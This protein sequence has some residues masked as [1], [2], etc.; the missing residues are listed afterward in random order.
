MKNPSAVRFAWVLAAFSL[1]LLSGGAACLAEEAKPP[2]VPELDAK[3]VRMKVPGKLVTDQVFR[4]SITMKNTG[5][6][7]W[8]EG[9]FGVKLLAAGPV[10]NT[11]WGTSYIILGQGRKIQPGTEFTFGSWLRAPGEPGEHVFQWQVAKARGTT[12][13]GETTE[14]RTITVEQRP[15]EPPP[16]PPVQ[17]KTGKHIL[18]FDDFAYA[19]SFKLPRKAAGGDPLFASSGLA[20]RTM[21]DG[22]KR[23]FLKYFRGG[24]FEAEIPPLVKLKDGDH[25]PL[26][27]AAVK[28][29]WGKFGVGGVGPNAEFWWDEGKKTLYWSSYHGYWTGGAKRPVLGASKRADDGK[30]THL[31]PWR[32]AGG[33]FKAYWG[34]VTNLPKSFADRYTGGRAFALGF[35]GYYSICG[36]TS[37][38]PSLG[39]AAEPDPKKKTLD[40][41]PL[42]ESPWGS[43]HPAPRDGEYFVVNSGWGGKPPASRTKGTWTMED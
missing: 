19:G 29:V 30:L 36:G 9:R 10:G 32:V 37:Q 17:P 8:A 28:T 31:G 22:S 4:A 25:K 38:G 7:T 5:T 43:G 15:E 21:T 2:A 13:F 18:T 24:I 41:V 27:V 35:G 23:L 20:L 39:A 33:T 3:F 11:T 40:L 1:G 16:T 12:V 14:A 26:K 42:L 6:A 34:G